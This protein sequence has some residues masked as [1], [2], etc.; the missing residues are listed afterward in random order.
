MMMHSIA[1]KRFPI[2]LSYEFIQK[3]YSFGNEKDNLSKRFQL[4]SNLRRECW[5]NKPFEHFDMYCF[6]PKELILLSRNNNK[7]YCKPPVKMES[8]MSIY[9][10]SLD[11]HTKKVNVKC[12]RCIDN[13]YHIGKE[14]EDI[15][16][17][18]NVIV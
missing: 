6:N 18:A 5:I 4:R 16:R 8:V 17:N 12:L 13:N 9:R 1:F 11:T 7:I 15:Y 14:L 10:L 2:G 3:G